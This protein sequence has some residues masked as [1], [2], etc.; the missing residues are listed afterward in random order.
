MQPKALLERR[1]M[2]M[3]Q[4]IQSNIMAL[5]VKNRDLFLQ[6]VPASMVR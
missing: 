6:R 3:K 2:E 4:G 1:K 5:S